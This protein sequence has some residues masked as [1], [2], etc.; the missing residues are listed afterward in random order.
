MNTLPNASYSFTLRLEIPNRVGMLSQV[1]NVISEAGGDLGAIDI[2]QATRD[3]MV[4]DI[5][6]SAGDEAHSDH[7]VEAVKQMADVRVINFQRPYLFASPGRQDH[8][9]E[10]NSTQN[11]RSAFDGLHARRGAYL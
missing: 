5:T 11:P 8:R 9:P 2:V 3:M 10:Q 6:V 1:M 7:I 4:R